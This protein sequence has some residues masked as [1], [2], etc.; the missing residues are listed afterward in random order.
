MARRVADATP[1]RTRGGGRL[2]WGGR[3]AGTALAG[4][5]GYLTIEGS[6]RLMRPPR[7]QLAAADGGPATPADLGFAYEDVEFAT[8]DGV[9]LSGWLMPAERETRA[10]VVLMHGFG[11]NRLADLVE[12]GPWLRRRYNVLQFDFRGHGGSGDAPI[13]LLALERHDAPAAVR[14]AHRQGLGPLALMGISLG[15]AVAI[16]AAPRLP[17]AAVVADA[18]FAELH[19]PV[20]N[21]MRM[22]GYPLPR[23][24]SR[25]IVAGSML[26]TRARA[27]DP[28]HRVADIAPRGLLLIAPRDDALIDYRQSV[29]L[30]AAAREPKE[31]FI[32]D[33]ATHSSAH[34]VGGP[35]YES[36]VLDFLARHLERAV[37][38][39][40]SAEPSTYT[41][42]TGPVAKR[43][44]PSI[45]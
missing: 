43:R 19:H 24:G 22:D 27:V 28:I 45:A 29:R 36:R 16:A 21:R 25:L 13:S 42:A 2:R 39:P 1:A 10:A 44:V 11:G 3:I 12:F 4:Y 38:G 32:V 41:S 31:L 23:L 20:A 35:A 37:E 9:T 30:Y 34:R 6:R 33:G 14:F 26:R 15:A 8:D 18:A 40:E 17:V 7:L 5:L